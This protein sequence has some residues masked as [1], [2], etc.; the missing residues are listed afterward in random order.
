MLNNSDQHN[1]AVIVLAAGCS[2]RLGEPKQ[3]VSF[4][5]ESLLL[6]QCKCALSISSN[7]TCVI[8]F[9]AEL[10]KKILADLP[11]NIVENEQWQNGLSSSIARGVSSLT[12]NIEHVMLLLIDQWQLSASNLAIFQDLSRQHP[13]HIISAKNAREAGGNIG[14]PVIFP[15]YSFGDLTALTHGN[16][17]KKVI[18]KYGSKLMTFELV[19]AFFDLDT[20]KQLA[21]LKQ[22]EVKN[23]STFSSIKS[24]KT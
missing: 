4:H 13:D 20:P 21:E 3:L 1:L 22:A 24:P 9:Q 12:E 5:E 6:R 10:M 2:S 15:K 19:S 8:G 18:E 11:I 17:A 23:K 14:P 16:G 7:V